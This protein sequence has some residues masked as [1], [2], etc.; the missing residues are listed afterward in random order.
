MSRQSDILMLLKKTP[1]TQAQLAQSI[2]RDRN[3]STYIYSAL[4]TLLKSGQI[5]RSDARPAV[6]S[7]PGSPASVTLMKKT[8]LTPRSIREIT[9]KNLEAAHRQVLATDHY[10]QEDALLA[11]CIR[12][13]PDNTDPVIVAM[14]IGLIDIT[15]STN[16]S[17]HK[18]RISVAE[19]AKHIVGIQHLDQRIRQGDP[20][21]VNDIA[22][23]N[24]QINLFS[25]AS[26]YCCYHNLHRDGRDD[27]SIFDNVLKRTLPLYFGDIS[28]R[29]IEQWRKNLQYE[30]YNAYIAEKLDMLSIHTAFRRREFDHFM[31]FNNR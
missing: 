15:N 25:F 23:C 19:L 3:H 27:Y 1:M 14:K 7:L 18:S 31:W 9:V 11:D 12:Q 10:G 29:E 13:Y 24:G 17:R 4:M 16:I 21:V 5:A 30:K 22:N 8:S 6:Y 20:Q 2:Y 26:K 28:V